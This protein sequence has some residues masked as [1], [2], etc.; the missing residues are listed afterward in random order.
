MLYLHLYVMCFLFLPSLLYTRQESVDISGTHS[1]K[2]K[3]CE[4]IVVE[5]HTVDKK[6][7]VPNV[8]PGDVSFADPKYANREGIPANAESKDPSY[9]A[10][11][12][13]GRVVINADVRISFFCY[14]AHCL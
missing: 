4:Y 2:P 9:F 8:G 6:P 1:G 3:T 10:S 11:T 5:A 7:L 13:L 14:G 12:L